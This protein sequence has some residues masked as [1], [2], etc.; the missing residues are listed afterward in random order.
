MS[1]A[2]IASISAS[3]QAATSV[4]MQV[5]VMKKTREV[6]KVSAEALVQL[7]QAATPSHIGTRLNVVA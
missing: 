6:E 7:V 1:D 5:A 2:L 3:Q 4:E